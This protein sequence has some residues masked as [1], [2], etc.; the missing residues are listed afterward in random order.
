MTK[1]LLII[2]DDIAI[3]RTLQLHFSSDEKEVHISHS[4]EEGLSVCDSITID[5]IILDIRM[6]GKSGLQILPDLKSKF[7]AVRVIMITAF[8]DMET[9]ITAMQQGADDYIHKPIDLD[10]LD[11]AVGKALRNG[12]STSVGLEIQP[13]DDQ[14]R[15]DVMVGHS[16]QMLD[17]FKTIGRI[18]SSPATVLITGESGTGKELVAQAIHRASMNSK[19]PFVPVNCAAMVETLLESDLFGHEKGAFTGAVS[20]QVGKFALADHG[21]LFLDEISELSLGM[22]AK[23]LRVLQEKEFS[24][25][26]S[27]YSL[28][29]DTRVIAATN[30]NLLEA[31]AANRF[32][33]DLYYRLQVVTIHLPALR[34]RNEDLP[35]LVQHLLGKI[36]RSMNRHVN[37]MS[38]DVIETLQ[39]Y[40]WPGNVR[41]LENVITKS[42]ALCS[43][44][45]ITSE[46]LPSL[47]GNLV[48]S[49]QEENES[50]IDSDKSLLDVEKVHISRV[51]ET[52]N[53][54]KGKTCEILGI[55]RPRLRRLIALHRIE[56]P[57]YALR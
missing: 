17:V 47:N 51:L 24:P 42:V 28:K 36:N 52:T 23:L 12:Q 34:D 43:G 22:Q 14:Y 37:R 5:L 27:K 8:H 55:S 13:D 38:L 48:S 31:M 21:T 11:T 29:V 9:T 45:I 32:R 44:D 39:G 3:C 18:A 6:S 53:W 54:H 10:E 4:A 41:E 57:G 33:D 56:S 7:P 2:D 46:M 16:R 19:G 30:V 1:R 25:I 50:Q 26:G 20:K 35:D 49:F 15:S 40:H